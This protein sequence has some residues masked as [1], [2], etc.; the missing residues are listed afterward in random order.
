LSTATAPTPRKK[1]KTTTSRSLQIAPKPFAAPKGYEAVVVEASD[2]ASE[3]SSLFDN[4]TDKQIWHISAPDAVSINA[5]KELD[6]QAA[7]RGESILSQNGVNYNMQPMPA[8]KDVF[9]LPE[10]TKSTYVPNGTN[11]TRRF[12]LRE[13]SGKPKSKEQTPVIFTATKEG[14]DK[15]IRQQPHGLKM[16]YYPYGVTAIPEDDVD[17]ADTFQMPED[18]ESSSPKDRSKTT[19][20]EV[21]PQEVNS[22][23]PEKKKKKKTKDANAGSSEKK[24]KKKK[25]LVDEGI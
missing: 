13:T 24:K 6:I 8:S 19:N 11:I 7:L 22:R 3:M 25:T 4:L 9:L 23:T 2:Y 17:M 10:G 16:R 14:A 5:I 12:N 20:G 18:V 15:S 1:A 21:E